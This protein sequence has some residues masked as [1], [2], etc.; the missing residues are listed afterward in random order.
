MPHELSKTSMRT[1][2]EKVM[3]RL[4]GLDVGSTI[5]GGSPLTIAAE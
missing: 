5:G 3:P 4:K 2:A 1:F